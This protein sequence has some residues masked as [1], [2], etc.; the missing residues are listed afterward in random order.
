ME[1]ICQL[2]LAS[3]IWLLVK[4]LLQV[5]LRA[6]SLPFSKVYVGSELHVCFKQFELEACKTLKMQSVYRL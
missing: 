2:V 1:F 4:H 6:E 3:E 5:D